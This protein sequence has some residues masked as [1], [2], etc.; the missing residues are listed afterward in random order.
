M[1]LAVKRIIAVAVAAA[2][3]FV[4]APATTVHAEEYVPQWAQDIDSH[5]VTFLQA[6]DFGS[7]EATQLQ[8]QGD[9]P[10]KFDLR[11]R[12]VVTPVKIQDPW[13]T[14]WAFAS[15]AAAETSIISDLGAPADLDLS[16][17]HL[18][19]YSM[20]PVKEVEAGSQA[21]EGITVFAE[22]KNGG[23]GVYVPSNR[24]IV[25]T[26]FSTGVGPVY[27]DDADDYCGFP[28]RGKAGITELD[29]LTKAEY[30]Q[31]V[32]EARKR[33]IIDAYGSLEDFTAA[34]KQATK[35]TSL[36]EYLDAQIEKEAKSLSLNTYSNIDD[37][38]IPEV[39]ES[40]EPNRNVFS[41]Y[42]LRHGNQLP[43][44]KADESGLNQ[45]GMKAVKQELMDGHGVCVGICADTSLPG[46]QSKSDYINLT[47]W[48]H[49]TYDLK[50]SNHS[51]CIVGWDDNYPAANFTH[52]IKDVDDKEAA[53]LTTPPGNGAWIVKNSW[54]CSDGC[55]TA[56]NDS[57]QIL[58]K[59]NWG[60]DGSGFFYVSYYDQSLSDPESF[61]FDDD[62]K[63][64]EF[65]SH[66]YDYLPSTAG[67]Y[68]ISSKM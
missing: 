12:G 28:Y 67:F 9:M 33:E 27:E 62:F 52:E 14:C 31:A 43:Y 30:R 11:D 45:Q 60:V 22:S 36:D 37:W 39:D 19:W 38:S 42:T 10:S 35:Y 34:I 61:E 46:Q 18:V 59:N 15:I 63:G 55:G 48:A 50:N 49:Y 66:V 57:S 58:G 6:Q 26:L 20:H 29:A 54:G 32:K 21:G 17:K 2:L 68:E 23:N 53:K 8:A 51:V 56:V 47:N 3:A 4:I 64:S 25:S 40:G 16:E 7:H 1:G 24:I 5:G 44:M 41:G 13:A 65:T